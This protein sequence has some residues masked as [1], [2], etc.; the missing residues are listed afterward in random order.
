[1]ATQKPR[2]NITCE[3]DTM[4]LLAELA[5]KRQQSTAGFAKELILE[6]LERREDMAL[7]RLAQSRDVAAAARI[8]HNNVWG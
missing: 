8:A 2:I 4:Y 1:M 7:A 5:K 6:A 3:E